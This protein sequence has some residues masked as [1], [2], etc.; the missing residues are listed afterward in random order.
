[1]PTPTMG[2]LL[3]NILNR[4]IIIGLMRRSEMKRSRPLPSRRTDIIIK[5]LRVV[6]NDPRYHLSSDASRRSETQVDSPRVPQ[7][8]IENAFKV[9][10]RG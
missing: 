4:K 10:R 9:R 8:T 1:M 2:S 7:N 3:R 6:S 5:K